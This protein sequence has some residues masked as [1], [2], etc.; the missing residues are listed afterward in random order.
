MIAPASSSCTHF[1]VASSDS[2]AVF[3]SIANQASLTLDNKVRGVYKIW[4]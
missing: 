1:R 2:E 4:H 3:A